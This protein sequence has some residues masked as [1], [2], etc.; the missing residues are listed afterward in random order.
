M[1]VF[2]CEFYEISKNNYLVEHVQT[3]A[4]DVLGYPYISRYFFCNYRHRLVLKIPFPDHIF[5]NISKYRTEN[6]HFQIKYYT[7][8][9][10]PYYLLQFIT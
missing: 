1:Q 5:T 10:P 4:S 2:S 8:P 7:P 3:A 9:R 6:L